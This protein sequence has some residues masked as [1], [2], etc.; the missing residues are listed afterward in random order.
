M[1]KHHKK[2]KKEQNQSLN[3]L[4]ESK[5]GPAEDTKK[6]KKRK[7][8]IG[9]WGVVTAGFALVFDTIPVLGP[10]IL[11]LGF[12]F[13]VIGLMKGEKQVSKYG[14]II[15]LLAIGPFIL[16]LWVNGTWPFK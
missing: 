13:S 6:V 12:V 16:G 8:G 10:I 3:R 4:S 14:L 1:F 2:R 9:E 11:V 15:A 5:R 7:L